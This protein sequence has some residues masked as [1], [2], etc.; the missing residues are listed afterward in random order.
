[1][2]EF[3][4][5][6]FLDENNKVIYIGRTNNITSRMSTHFSNRGHLPKECYEAVKRIDYMILKTTNDMKIKELYYIGKYKPKFNSN[7][8]SDVSFVMNEL[9]DVWILFDKQNEE[10]IIREIEQ[11]TTEN[12]KKT[13]EI[14]LLKLNS[15]NLQKEIESLK[16]NSDDLQKEIDS[17]KQE[18]KNKTRELDIMRA[19]KTLAG[20]VVIESNSNEVSFKTAVKMLLEK[21]DLMFFNI[22]ENNLHYTLYNIS[23]DVVSKIHH[24]EW[25]WEDREFIVHSD[26]SEKEFTPLYNPENKS[27]NIS[28]IEI[29][30]CNNWICSQK[31]QFNE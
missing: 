6:R 31:K 16:L 13:K 23:G 8:K 24:K 14:E 2:S 17:L 25:N 12:N 21:P 15:D 29:M 3:Y 22:V 20:G 19:K 18:L 4:V 27:K 1:M 10:K 30:A 9:E 28:S 11:L 26:Y 5:Y 7:D